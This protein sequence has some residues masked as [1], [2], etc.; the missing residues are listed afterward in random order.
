MTHPIQPHF[1][2]SVDIEPVAKGRPVFGRAVKG[3]PRAYTPIKTRVYEQELGYRLK[4]AYGNRKPLEGAL[5]VSIVFYL[6][7]AKSNKKPYPTQAPDADNLGKAFCDAANQILWKDDS[8]IVELTLI[9]L[10]ANPKPHIVI[11]V[12]EFCA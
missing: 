3:R 6:S 4:L 7:K 9:K 1:F 2:A 11:R 5:R 12:D 8:Q 10:W